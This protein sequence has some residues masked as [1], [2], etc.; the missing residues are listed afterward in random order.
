MYVC[1][2]VYIYFKTNVYLLPSIDRLINIHICIYTKMGVKDGM[3]RLKSL[4]N[5]LE[6]LSKSLGRLQEQ[7]EELSSRLEGIYI[8]MYV[9]T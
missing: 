1:M 5:E 6:K 4:D 3:N 8:Y 2:Y 9:F 7:G